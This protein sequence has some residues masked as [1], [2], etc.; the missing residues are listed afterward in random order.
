MP[1]LRLAL[2]LAIFSVPVPIAAGVAVAAPGP[3][4]YCS[5]TEYCISRSYN[6]P[7]G[8]DPNMTYG[9]TADWWD[10]NFY[11]LS[12]QSYSNGGRD[13]RREGVLDPESQWAKWGNDV[14]LRGERPSELLE[15]PGQVLWADVGQPLWNRCHEFGCLQAAFFAGQLSGA[16]L[17]RCVRLVISLSL[18]GALAGCGQSDPQPAAATLPPAPPANTGAVA[19][20]AN[21]DVEQNEPSKSALERAR[22]LTPTALVAFTPEEVATVSLAAAVLIQDCARESDI[23]VGLIG[24]VAADAERATWEQVVHNVEFSDRQRV[25]EVGYGLPP[26]EVRSAEA[27]VPDTILSELNAPGGCRDRAYEELGAPSGI[28]DA[29][30]FEAILEYERDALPRWR[31]ADSTAAERA[32]WVA[33]MAEAGFEGVT[34]DTPVDFSEAGI[35]RAL[36]DVDCRGQ[37]GLRERIVEHHEAVTAEAAALFATEIRAAEEQRAQLVATATAV[38]QAS[39]V[40]ATD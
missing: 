37:S 38:V 35:P 29:P 32:A 4:T 8:T 10:A 24:T 15:C 2:A 40:A 27:T 7:G 33:C 36:A 3:D 18:A 23:S 30:A 25:A 26:D 17:M 12:S 16:T 34:L 22:Q 20:D 21:S 9:W 39:G 28:L 19:S 13:R 1:R 14:H 6:T 11:S 31:T 5:N